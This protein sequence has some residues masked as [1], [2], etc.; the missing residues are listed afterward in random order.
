MAGSTM[1]IVCARC[2]SQDVEWLG[3]T[4]ASVFVRCGR[5]LDV[6][7]LDPVLDAEHLAAE[8]ALHA[9][10]DHSPTAVSV[11]ARVSAR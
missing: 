4:P 10:P 9:A 6:W 7:R 5:C 2:G 3:E 11:R 1:A 8:R